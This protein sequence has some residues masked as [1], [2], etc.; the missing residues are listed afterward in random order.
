M[1]MINSETTNYADGFIRLVK[2]VEEMNQLA[3]GLF[4]QH[5]QSFMRKKENSL[6]LFENW[7]RYRNHE[8][9]DDNADKQVEESVRAHSFFKLNN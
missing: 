3:C 4:Y 9:I 7:L 1:E 8:I 5:D 2:K 6:V